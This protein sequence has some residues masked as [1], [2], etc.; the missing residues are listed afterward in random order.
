[1]STAEVDIERVFVYT[2]AVGIEVNFEA[3]KEVQFI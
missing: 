3:D 2:S 1:L